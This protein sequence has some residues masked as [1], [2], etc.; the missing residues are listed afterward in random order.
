MGTPALWTGK[1]ATGRRDR[2]ALGERAMVGRPAAG[3]RSATFLGRS[4][5]VGSGR[6]AHAASRARA[7]PLA[8]AAAAGAPSRPAGAGRPPAPGASRCRRAPAPPR[9]HGTGRRAACAVPGRRRQA[10]RGRGRRSGAGPRGQAWIEVGRV[11][12]AL[13]HGCRVLGPK[14][15]QVGLDPGQHHVAVVQLAEQVLEVAGTAPRRLRRLAEAELGRLEDVAK[16]LRGDAHV[17]LVADAVE[18]QGGRGE[19][20]A[21]RRAGRG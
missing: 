1:G 20:A 4:S 15:R 3:R 18:L 16:A 19:G 13:P 7:A 17:V 9:T 10:P 12:G 5:S 11:A 8:R 6:R 2:G 21:S 14:R